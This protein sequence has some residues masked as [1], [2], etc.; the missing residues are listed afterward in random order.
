[1][2]SVLD[3]FSTLDGVKIIFKLGYIP[4]DDELYELTCEQYQSY[5]D[6]MEE[7]DDISR[8][9]KVYMILPK[10]TQKYVELA[11]DDVYTLTEIDISYM[12]KAEQIIEKYCV[13]SGKIFNNLEEKLYYVASVLPPVASQGT[14]YDRESNVL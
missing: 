6:T 7:D 13:Q 3:I 5:Y 4:Q 12:R 8:D 2:G 1:M 9:T 11:G 14:K 10:D